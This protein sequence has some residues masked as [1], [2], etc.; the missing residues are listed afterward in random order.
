MELACAV[1]C[2]EKEF[3]EMNVIEEMK[4]LGPAPSYCC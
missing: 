4:K 3:L 1:L 2:K